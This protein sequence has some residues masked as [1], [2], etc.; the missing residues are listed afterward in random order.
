MARPGI[1]YFI[2]ALILLGIICAQPV[3]AGQEEP[4][5]IVLLSNE[6][7]VG[8]IDPK[9]CRYLKITLTNLSEEASSCLIAFY[10]ERVELSTD[11]VG[12]AE[13]RTFALE[14]PGESRTLV[15]T[16]LNFDEFTLNV[17]TGQIQIAI[18]KTLYLK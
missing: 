8:K 6:Q 18:E 16:T 2:P 3:Y 15:W 7:Y 13:S 10:K 17:E 11:R 14:K 12:P 1:T 5:R 4:D 9:K